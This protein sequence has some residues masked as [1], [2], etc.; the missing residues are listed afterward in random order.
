M[1]ATTTAEL[2]AAMGTN[3]EQTVEEDYIPSWSYVTIVQKTIE[4]QTML[5]EQHP[6]F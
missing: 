6:M 1:P 3:N 2:F 4:T 5:V